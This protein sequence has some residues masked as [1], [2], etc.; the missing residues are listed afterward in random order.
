MIS[1]LYEMGLIMSNIYAFYKIKSR[2]IHPILNSFWFKFVVDLGFHKYQLDKWVK[3]KAETFSAS[4]MPNNAFRSST[5]MFLRLKKKKP[6]KKW[7]KFLDEIN[8][9]IDYTSFIRSEASGWQL[10]G[11]S[12]ST[13]FLSG[14]LPYKKSK[15]S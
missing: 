8:A 13:F 7:W 6:R 12:S 14:K 15:H 9:M 3:K 10:S 2:I 1:L 5:F 11:L 4:Y